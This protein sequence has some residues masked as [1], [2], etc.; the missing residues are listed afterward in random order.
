MKIETRT[1]L[2]EL[3]SYSVMLITPL[4]KEITRTENSTVACCHIILLFSGCMLMGFF[5]KSLS[6]EVLIQFQK[7]G[8]YF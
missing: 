5:L 7:I 8:H 3:T 1:K 2:R 6:V 4:V